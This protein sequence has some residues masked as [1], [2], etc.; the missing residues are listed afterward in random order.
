VWATTQEA[1][2]LHGRFV[3]ASWDIDE[4]STGETWRRLEENVDYLRIGIVGLKG[5][6]EA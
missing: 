2:F 5:A 3:W 6:L 4:Y 1:S